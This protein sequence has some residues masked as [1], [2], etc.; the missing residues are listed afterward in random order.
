MKHSVPLLSSAHLVLYVREQKSPVHRCPL[1][2]AECPIFCSQYLS[3]SS[4]STLSSLLRA[5]VWASGTAVKSRVTNGMRTC[6]SSLSS[7]LRRTNNH[8]LGGARMGPRERKRKGQQK[9]PD[10]DF[11]PN[12]WAQDI[13]GIIGDLLRSSYLSAESLY[14]YQTCAAVVWSTGN[15]Q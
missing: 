1:P 7:P 14:P 8:T 6:F 12:L 4:I 9:R 10:S 3:L 5:V 11:L 13:T 2:N 15:S